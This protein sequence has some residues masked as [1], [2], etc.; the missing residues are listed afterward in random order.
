MNTRFNRIAN[1]VVGPNLSAGGLL[2]SAVSPRLAAGLRGATAVGLCFA[3]GCSRIPERGALEQEISSLESRHGEISL[4]RLAVTNV[5][6]SWRGVKGAVWEDVPATR[7]EITQECV[8]ES[9]FAEARGF[10]NRY[11]YELGFVG[12]GWQTAVEV[13]EP[14]RRLR[15]MVP[16]LERD[17]RLSG[18]PHAFGGGIRY[19]PTAS[20]C[21]LVGVW[22]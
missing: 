15:Q 5:T 21:A 14:E 16:V 13:G 11:D 17:M 3:A 19:E 7:V 9:S 12:D 20:E 1:H 6:S 10:T 2:C 4:P 18:S 22:W 8:S